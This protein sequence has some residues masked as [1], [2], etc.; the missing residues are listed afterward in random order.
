MTTGHGFSL[1]SGFNKI[2]PTTN[3]P[4]QGEKGQHG[5]WKNYSRRTSGWAEKQVE[6]NTYSGR[7]R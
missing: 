5:S 4:L 2:L 3:D 1:K 6:K 7:Q